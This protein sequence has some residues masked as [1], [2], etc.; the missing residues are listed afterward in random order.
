MPQPPAA[1]RA[2]PGL[3]RRS[4]YIVVH[5]VTTGFQKV[6]ASNVYGDFVSQIAVLYSTKFHGVGKGLTGKDMER[7]VREMIVAFTLKA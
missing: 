2:C 5:E 1:L 6:N 3:Y 4:F 7:A